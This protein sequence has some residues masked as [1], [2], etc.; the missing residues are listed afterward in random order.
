MPNPFLPAYPGDPSY[1]A[2]DTADA[3]SALAYAQETA[4]LISLLQLATNTHSTHALPKDQIL[5][6]TKAISARAEVQF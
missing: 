6:I 2:Q 4:N 5:A 3:I 1:T